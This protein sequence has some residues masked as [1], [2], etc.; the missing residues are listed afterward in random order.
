MT[1]ADTAVALGVDSKSGKIWSVS[2]VNKISQIVLGKFCLALKCLSLSLDLDVE[3][4]PKALAAALSPYSDEDEEYEEEPVSAQP[5][6]NYASGTAI[7]A[8]FDALEASELDVFEV[9]LKNYIVAVFPK[10]AQP[11]FPTGNS[12]INS[13]V[14]KIEFGNISSLAAGL[15]GTS[16]SELEKK[17]DAKIRS[18]LNR[19]RRNR[20]M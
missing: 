8:M 11:G 2:Q 19:F 6:Q 9:E 7:D 20:G 3:E 4:D 17:I 15:V 12:F 13:D 14:Y 18:G 5:S 16:E 10:T 1:L